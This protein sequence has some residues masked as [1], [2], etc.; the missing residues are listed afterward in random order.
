MRFPN[1]YSEWRASAMSVAV[2][3]PIP[4]TGGTGEGFTS[5]GWANL[6]W[7]GMLIVIFIVG[8]TAAFVGF[9]NLRSVRRISP[10]ADNAHYT[11]ITNGYEKDH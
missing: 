5:A 8:L 3:Q 2:L 7:I 11:G 9:R 4:G 10:R 1:G 6:L